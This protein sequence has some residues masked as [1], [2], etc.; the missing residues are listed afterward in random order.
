MI[1]QSS[2]IFL[3]I[4]LRIQVVLF[5]T[6]LPFVNLSKGFNVDF[7]DPTTL[8]FYPHISLVFLVAAL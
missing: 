8:S 1:I 5:L 2:M 3:P 4:F 7:I 6:N